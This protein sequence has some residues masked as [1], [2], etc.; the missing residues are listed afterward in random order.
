MT[1]FNADG[2]KMQIPDTK[3]E[4]AEVD[5]YIPLDSGYGSFVI[6]WEP[7]NA[8]CY[9]VM[10]TPMDGELCKLA[11]FDFGTPDVYLVTNFLTGKSYPFVMGGGLLALGYIAEKLFNEKPLQP[12]VS[13]VGR[14]IGLNLHRDV[15]LCTDESGRMS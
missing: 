1:K 14:I 5:Y 12:D 13:E 4:W 3:K 9:R 8:T 7:G 11:G 2:T 6:K 15:D 10:F